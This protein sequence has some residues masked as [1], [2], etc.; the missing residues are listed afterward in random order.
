MSLLELV[1]DLALVRHWVHSLDGPKVLGLV[2]EWLAR[3]LAV[4]QQP[5]GHPSVPQLEAGSGPLL[6]VASDLA[7]VRHWVHSLGGRKVLVLAS[8]WLVGDL[9]VQQQPLDHR[10]VLP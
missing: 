2:F 10:W 9:A 3:D 7:S 6:V 8:E 1:T 4:R 5:L